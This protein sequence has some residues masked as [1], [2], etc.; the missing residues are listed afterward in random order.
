MWEGEQIRLLA[1]ETFSAFLL[2]GGFALMLHG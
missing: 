1:K 2:A